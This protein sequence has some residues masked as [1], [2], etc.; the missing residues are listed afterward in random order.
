MTQWSRQAKWGL[1]QGVAGG[2]AIATV[3]SAGLRPLEVK[4]Q[5]KWVKLLD[6]RTRQIINPV[7]E[8][9]QGE[10]SKFGNGQ[11]GRCVQLWTGW[12]WCMRAIGG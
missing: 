1:E 9:G 12:V 2:Q 6:R 8:L 4:Y 10:R 7:P 3:E 5:R 11:K